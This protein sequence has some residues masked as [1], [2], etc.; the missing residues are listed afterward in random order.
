MMIIID[1]KSFEQY[2][3]MYIGEKSEMPRVSQN[4]ERWECVVVYLH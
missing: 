3:D 4:S 1:I 2:V